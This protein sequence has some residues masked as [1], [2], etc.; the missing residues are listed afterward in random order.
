MKSENAFHVK[1][2]I[3]TGLGLLMILKILTY[4]YLT[5]QMNTYMENY[6]NL[7]SVIIKNKY[8]IPFIR[9]FYLHTEL[10]NNIGY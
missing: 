7:W 9:I 4:S 2:I 3:N 6:Q 10:M 5:F 8:P 1:Q